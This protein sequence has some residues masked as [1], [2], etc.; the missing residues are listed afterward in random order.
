MEADSNRLAALCAGEVAQACL[1]EE[2]AMRLLHRSI[3]RFEKEN[4][5]IDCLRLMREALLGYASEGRVSPGVR[6][7]FDNCI[8]TLDGEIWA[9]EHQ[10][11]AAAQTP[12]VPPAAPPQNPPKFPRV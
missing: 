6:Q 10:R 7:R 2:D 4:T 5:A 12:V 3:R 9:L 1:R 11:K 8:K